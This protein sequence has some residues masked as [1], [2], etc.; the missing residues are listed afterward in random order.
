MGLAIGAA[1]I[2]AAIAI[3]WKFR[4]SDGNAH[5]VMERPFIG[6]ALPVVILGLA[7]SGI[8]FIISWYSS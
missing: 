8:G 5:P 3:L 7:V 1:S 6:M 4:A 2:L